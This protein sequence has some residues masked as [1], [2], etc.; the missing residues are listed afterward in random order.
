MSPSVQTLTDSINLALT[1]EYL[2]LIEKGEVDVHERVTDLRAWQRGEIV[3]TDGTVIV[4]VFDTD[5]PDAK[6]AKRFVISVRE[7]DVA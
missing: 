4:S 3:R 6:A 2:H 1:D 5:Q 7:E